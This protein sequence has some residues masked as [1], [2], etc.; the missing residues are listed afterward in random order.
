MAL[1]SGLAGQI[2]FVTEST[3]GVAKAPT[4]FLPFV[5]EAIEYQKERL[6]SESIIAGRRV[7]DSDQWNGG[8]NTVSGDIG[9]EL[10][11]RG[12]GVLFKHMFGGVATT[13]SGPYTHTFTPGDL[14]GVAFTTQVGVPGVGG[15]VHPKTAAG[16]K[17]MSW[18]LACSAGEIATLGL[19]VTGQRLQMGT[20]SV[21]DGVTT[22]GSPTLESAAAD[23]T[24]ADL[25]K[26]VSGTGIPT[27]AYITDVA[28]DGSSATMSANATADGT[29]LAVVIGMALGAVSLPSGIKPLKFNHG[30]VTIGGTAVPVKAA[31]LKGDNGL[32]DDRRFIGDQNISEPLEAERRVYDGTLDLEFTDLTQYNRFASGDEFALVLA[33]TAGADSVTITENIRYDGA[34]AAVGGRGIVEQSIPFK[35]IGSTDAEAITAVLVNSDSSA[36]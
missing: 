4:L 18:E 20:R 17:V 32:A 26:T 34:P 6:E 23:F 35:A 29:S 12:L 31:S 1:K 22:N 28:A 14:S 9:L 11:N 8:N 2:G 5:S 7:L 36:A 27:G 24:G 13:G 19:T 15:T 21:S 3:A 25:Y 33:F 16:C 30:S 10:M